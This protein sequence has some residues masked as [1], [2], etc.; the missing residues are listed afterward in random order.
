M[1]IINTQ[2]NLDAPL[3]LEP[4]LTDSKSA[5]LPLEEGAIKLVD[6]AGLEPELTGAI[7]LVVSLHALKWILELDSNQRKQSQSLLSYR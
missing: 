4:R 5:L 1:F 6:I 2:K 3:G 7:W